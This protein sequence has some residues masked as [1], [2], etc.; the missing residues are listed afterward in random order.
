VRHSLAATRRAIAAF[1]SESTIARGT[2]TWDN[3]LGLLRRA[4]RFRRIKRHR[5]LPQLVRALR[6]DTTVEA[7]A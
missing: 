7:A 1:G 5:A 6:P 2:A 4:A 3:P